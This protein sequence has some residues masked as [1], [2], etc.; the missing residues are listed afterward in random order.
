MKPVSPLDAQFLNA[1][2]A[3]TTGHVGAVVTLDP[4]TGPAGEMTLDGLRALL[5]PRLHLAP[6]FRQRLV[7]V[8]LGLGNPYWVDDPDFD[9]EFHLREL[10][11]PGP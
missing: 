4:S 9:L 1:E 6:P 7:D 11:L 5:E 3:T 10:A 8:P 2:D